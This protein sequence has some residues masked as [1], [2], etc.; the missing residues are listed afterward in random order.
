[1]D[2]VGLACIETSSHRQARPE[3]HVAVSS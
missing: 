2:D 3:L 1:V